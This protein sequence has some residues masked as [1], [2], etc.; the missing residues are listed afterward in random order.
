MAVAPTDVLL[1]AVAGAHGV[2][3]DVK[4]K[5]FTGDPAAVADYGQ[6]HTEDGR[7]FTLTVKQPVKGGMV[8]KLDGVTDRDQ[9]Q[10]LKGTRLY[11]PRSALGEAEPDEDGEEAYFHADLVGCVLVDEHNKEIGRVTAVHDFGAGDLLDVLRSDEV[12]AGK[13]LLVP[14]TR[15][16]CPEVDIAARRIVC[17]PPV[18]LLDDAESEAPDDDA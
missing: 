16:V 14:F 9:A 1:C 18:G 7:R 10:A 8:A 17:V 13:S 15:A 3:G 2:R 6:V 4:I 11:V 5:T 12:G